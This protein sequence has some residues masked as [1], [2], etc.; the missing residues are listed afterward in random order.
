MKNTKVL[1]MLNNGQIEELKALLQDEIFTES[2]KGNGNAK[3][4]YA[5][6]KRYFKYADKNNHNEALKKPCKEVVMPDGTYNSFVDGYTLVLTTEGI[7]EIEAYDTTKGTYFDVRKMINYPSEYEMV[8]VNKILAEAKSKNYAFK[9]SE[10]GQG[11]DF[12]YCFKYKEGY[13]K[14]GLL[15]Q[16]YSIIDDGEKAEVYYNGA[17]G[18][19]FIKTSLGVCGILPFNADAEVCEKKTVIEVA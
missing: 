6:M 4:R 3:K 8:D 5:A 16:A 2:L 17:K 1:E 11:M 19:L 18:L 14:V 10:I 13:F 15:D 12:Q 7:G 9:K